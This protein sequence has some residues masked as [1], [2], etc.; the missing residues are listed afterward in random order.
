MKEAESKKAQV[1]KIGEEFSV[2]NHVPLPKGETFSVNSI[3]KQYTD[4]KISLIGEHQTENAALAVMA[5]I[6]LTQ[7][8]AFQI[9]EDD[10]RTG[11]EAAYWPG[12]FEIIS[13]GPLI[14]IDGAHNK[15]GINSLAAA[16]QE[17][18]PNKKIHVVFAALNDKKLD[19]MINKIDE[20]AADVTFVD[21]PFQRA[22][23]AAQLYHIS[24]S[25]NKHQAAN[26]R[27]LLINKL[28]LLEKDEVLIITGSLYFISEVKPFLVQLRQKNE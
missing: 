18:Y 13:E 26:W 27:E 5:S 22:A 2:T 21:F 1:Y 10:V 19:E 20:L 17:R 15:E 25:L 8:F 12:R 14:I 16:I 11:L 23:S 28:Q 3:F 6:Y 9:E 4:L 24:K 7:F